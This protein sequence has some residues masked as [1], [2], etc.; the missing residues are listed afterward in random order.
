MMNYHMTDSV[1]LVTGA[2]GLLGSAIIRTLKQ[3]K[4]KVIAFVQTGQNYSSLDDLGVEI[5]M[6]D[7]L[8]PVELQAALK[9][10]DVVIHTAALTDIWPGRNPLLWKVNL[11]GTRN[12]VEAAEQEKISKLIY[13]GTANSFG[14]GS[15][16]D[17]GNETRPYAAKKY[18]VDYLDSKY[19]TQQFILDKVKSTAFPA[20]VVNPTF[21]IGPCE[22]EKGSIQMIRAVVDGKVPGYTRGGRNYIYVYDA[23]RGIIN[24]IEKGR[25]GECYILGNQ[26]LSYKE[27]FSLIAREAGVKAPRIPLNPVLALTYAA[28]LSFLA[29]LLR[30]APKVSIAMARISKDEHYYSAGKAV[31]ELNLPQTPIE[32][33]VREALGSCS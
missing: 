30:K 20:V 23:V 2:T 31:E 6:G 22:S 4:Q 11:E 33:A 15:K 26:N 3:E 24:A 12:L 5:R 13:V 32:V 1:I 14:F 17:P 9:G 28:I 7:L 27:M 18:H 25:P 16:N 29:G 19:A 10:V 21:M 8:H